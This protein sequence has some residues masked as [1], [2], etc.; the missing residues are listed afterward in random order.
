MKANFNFFISLLISSLISLSLSILP[1]DQNKLYLIIDGHTFKADLESNELVSNLKGLL[2]LKIKM[3]DD[4]SIAKSYIFSSSL[5][6]VSRGMS[7]NKNEEN[8]V[9]EF[10]SDI[11]AGDIIMYEGK[12]LTI[13]YDSFKS[14]SKYVKIGHVDFN[15]LEEL[16]NT[17]GK[18]DIDITWITCNPENDDCKVPPSSYF[19]VDLHFLTWKVLSF[20]CFL[21]L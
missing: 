4:E 9:G 19:V 13:F 21:F 12:Y 18:K 6:Y 17:L 16:R 2:P 15:D 11:Q 1:Q 7:K 5:G 3:F 20:L 14:E 8:K 10:S